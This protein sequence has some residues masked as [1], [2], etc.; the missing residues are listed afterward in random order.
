MRDKEFKKLLISRYRDNKASDAELEA[1]FQ[2]MKEGSLDEAL[3]DLNK[4]ID[5]T[6]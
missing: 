1:F 6:K 5:L 2:L 3:E 4:E